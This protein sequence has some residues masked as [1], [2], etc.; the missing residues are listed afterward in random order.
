MAK[1]SGWI[2]E[3][4]RQDRETDDV[5]P[6]FLPGRYTHSPGGGAWLLHIT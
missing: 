4:K 1:G 2:W 5:L 3:G 6:S